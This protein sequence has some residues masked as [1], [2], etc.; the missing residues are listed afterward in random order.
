MKNFLI[1]IG[2]TFIFSVFY[3]NFSIDAYAESVE[4]NNQEIDPVV[5]QD[6]EKDGINDQS[7]VDIKI[8]K[9]SDDPNLISPLET[10]FSVSSLGTKD[11]I[12]PLGAGEWDY[13]GYS[14]FKS[15]SKTFYSGGGNLRILIAQPYIGPGFKWLYK[16]VEEDPVINDTV[17]TFELP[18]SSGTYAVDFNVSSFVDG[19]NNKAELHLNKLT[20]PTTIVATEWYD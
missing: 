3:I 17:S 1:T 18:N 2:M 6:G 20:N 15:Q 9:V 7:N 12:S 4:N 5:A 11:L 8:T 10:G 13:L 16:L 14:E 19:D